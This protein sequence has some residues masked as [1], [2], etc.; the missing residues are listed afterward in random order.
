MKNLIIKFKLMGNS[1][2]YS[3]LVTFYQDNTRIYE[4]VYLYAGEKRI[5]FST[6]NNNNRILSTNE[7]GE[8][9]LSEENVNEYF[10]DILFHSLKSNDYIAAF[11]KAATKTIQQI[12]REIK[13]VKKNV[14]I[15]KQQEVA[16]TLPL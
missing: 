2:N 11:K 5:H 1:T 16:H 9:Y 13:H 15:Y 3:T 12:K 14:I 8:V 10:Y 6:K 4:N 7:A